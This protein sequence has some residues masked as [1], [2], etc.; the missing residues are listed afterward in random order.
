MMGWNQVMC[1]ACWIEKRGTWEKVEG[2]ENDYV[3]IELS[4]PVRFVPDDPTLNRCSYCGK[5]TFVG[6]YVRDDP[7][8]VPFPYE[9][10]EDSAEDG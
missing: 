3:L 10:E 4:M 1:E 6:I 2:T 9:P 8:K 7:T 5:P